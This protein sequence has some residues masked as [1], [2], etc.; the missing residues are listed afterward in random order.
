MKKG[1]NKRKKY[2][3]DPNFQYGFIRKIAVLTTFII[4]VSLSFLVFVYHYY[5]DVRIEITQPVPFAL[6]EGEEAVEASRSY[7]ILELLWPVL[8]VCVIA[9]LSFV[10]L[11][12]IIIS[13]R[14]A[15][16][17]YRMRQILAKMAKYDLSG[18]G[19]CLRKRDDFKSLLYEVNNL[20]E[21]LRIPI[22]ELQLLCQEMNDEE[23]QKQHVDRIREIVSQFKIKH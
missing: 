15:G 2:I 14:M 18:P 22:Q 19:E 5:G 23:K 13:H 20:K 1:I 6:S 21:Q 17:V 10:V 9:T 7:T 3:I 16:P 4:I 11:Y 12:G 8:T